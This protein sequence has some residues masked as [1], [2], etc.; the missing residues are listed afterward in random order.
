MVYVGDSIG[1][2]TAAEEAGEQGDEPHQRG[3]WK[4]LPEVK[5]PHQEGVATHRNPDTPD[6]AAKGA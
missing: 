5:E 3:V 2:C 1:I 6:M 4:L